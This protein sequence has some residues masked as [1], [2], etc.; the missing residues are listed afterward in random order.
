MQDKQGVEETHAHESLAVGNSEHVE[1]DGH[2]NLGQV[3]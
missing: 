3:I 2:E 1:D